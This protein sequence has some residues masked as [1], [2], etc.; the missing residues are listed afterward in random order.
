MSNFYSNNLLNSPVINKNVDC[1][2][3]CNIFL[4]ILSCCPTKIINYFSPSLADINE[5]FMILLSATPYPTVFLLLCL[6]AYFRTSRSVLLL[7]MVFL[8]NF[9]VI[10]LKSII[11]EPRPNYLCNAEYGY[12][13]NH[14]CFF[15]CILFWFITEEICTPEFFQFKYK[16]YLIPFVLVYPLILYSRYYLYY[17]SFG[18]IIGGIILGIIIGIGW[19]LI[20][21]K[22]ILCND[23][24]LTQLMIKFNIENNLTYDLLYQDDG[25]VL[26]DEYQSLIKKE[27]ELI[28]MKQKLKKVSKNIKN[29]EGLEGLNENLQD[30]LNNDFNNK[31]NN[32]DNQE[33]EEDYN[34]DVNGEV[35]SDENINESDNNKN[36]ENQ[37]N[38]FEKFKKD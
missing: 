32:Y 2:I 20:C 37:F 38:N 27:N 29:L 24:I 18:Q 12:P 16:L 11:R 15:T 5:I 17:H 36:F 22:L 31:N 9:T 1:S 21:T 23:N 7:L 34:N 25:Y 3:P 33:E 13:S 19:F 26:L 35:N 30:I 28:G 4:Y 8:E 14:T 10:A 6:A